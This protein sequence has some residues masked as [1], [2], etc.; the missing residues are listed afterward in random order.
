MNTR[1][2][3]SPKTKNNNETHQVYKGNNTNGFQS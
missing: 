3:K 1:E 2:R